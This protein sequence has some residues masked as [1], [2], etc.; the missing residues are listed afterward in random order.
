MPDGVDKTTTVQLQNVPSRGII[1]RVT[2]ILRGTTEILNQARVYDYVYLH[3]LGE[4]GQNKRAKS[5]ADSIFGQLAYDLL[6][7]NTLAGFSMSDTATSGSADARFLSA[8]D[9]VPVS[10]GGVGS[11]GF[12]NAPHPLDGTLLSFDGTS[13]GNTAVIE[14][15]TIRTTSGVFP[16][17]GI[18]Y[19]TQSPLLSGIT[20]DVEGPNFTENTNLYL[21]LHSQAFDYTGTGIIDAVFLVDIEPTH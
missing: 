3:Y 14:G 11:G 10:C 12:Y 5:Y 20:S 1:R 18:Y 13:D 7:R 6:N 2:V 16:S 8:V 19:D 15:A 21:T 17:S 4:S 9:C